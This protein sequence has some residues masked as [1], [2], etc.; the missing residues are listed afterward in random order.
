AHL[1][2]TGCYAS[3]N[4]DDVAA[5]LGVDLVVS[6]AEKDQL[7][8]IVS[9]KF[10]IKTMPLIA[11]EPEQTSLFIRG[12]HRAFI[13]IQDGCR[14]RCTYCIVTVAR[15]EERSRSKVEIINEINDLYQQGLQ[16]VVLTGVHVGG[17]GSDLNSSLYQLVTHILAE[18]DIPRI[19]FASVEPWD[20]PPSFFALFENPR[21]MPH[22]HLPIQSGVDSVLRRMSRRCKTAEFTTLVQQIRQVVPHFNVTTDIIVGF[23]GE[24]EAEWQQT[25]E[26]VESVGFGHLHVFPFSPR[27]GTKAAS[28]ANPIAKPIKKQRSVEM[29]ALGDRLR[30]TFYEQHI[31]TTADVLWERV[32]KNDVGQFLVS[33]YSPNYLKVQVVVPSVDYENTIE[34]IT[35]SH[36]INDSVALSGTVNYSPLKGRACKSSVD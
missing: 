11:M 6:N 3:L 17:Y 24:T 5:T 36:Y 31:G 10:A 15:G 33:G 13:K 30:Q 26:Y 1:V 21:L 32:Q 8:A 34:A 7:A 2:V 4:Q 20:L 14:Y 29:R 22:M 28:L 16:E 9:D 23:P 25:L 12:R 19:R 18:T 27:K 35:F